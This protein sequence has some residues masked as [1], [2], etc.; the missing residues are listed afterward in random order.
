MAI[1]DNLIQTGPMMVQLPIKCSDYIGEN[2]DPL[3][4]HWLHHH[5]EESKQSM[6]ELGNSCFLI[7]VEFHLQGVEKRMSAKAVV[8]S[9]VAKKRNPNAYKDTDDDDSSQNEEDYGYDV[10]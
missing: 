3:L 8:S 5:H 1:H 9:R 10:D 2:Q 7:N 4:C 6:G